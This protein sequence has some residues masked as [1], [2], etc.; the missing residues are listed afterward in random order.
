MKGTGG[1]LIAD[2]RGFSFTAKALGAQYLATTSTTADDDIAFDDDRLMLGSKVVLVKWDPEGK[3][4]V[5]VVR[6]ETEKVVRDDGVIVY[7]CR[8]TL[9]AFSWVIAEQ[10]ISTFSVEVLKKT[11]ELEKKGASLYDSLDVAPR[12]YPHLSST[13]LGD[14]LYQNALGMYTKIFF[15]FA[16][17]FWGETEYAVS[18]YSTDGYSGDFAPVWQV[19]TFACRLFRCCTLKNS[20]AP[21]S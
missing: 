10:F 11:V 13:D 16:F 19:S 21:F 15:Q 6:C 14:A 9:K 17:N 7:P 3:D 20:F 1:Y 12:F 8:R 2:R 5:E 18:A 4:K